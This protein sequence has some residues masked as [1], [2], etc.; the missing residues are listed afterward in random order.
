MKFVTEKGWIEVGFGV[1]PLD[2]DI[3][4]IVDVLWFSHGMIYEFTYD[5]KMYDDPTW[6]I[7]GSEVAEEIVT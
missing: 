5:N 3:G 1:L 2:P 6:I 4:E 7:T